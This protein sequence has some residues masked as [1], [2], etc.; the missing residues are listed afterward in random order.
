MNKKEFITK[1]EMC[2]TVFYCG[3]LVMFNIHVYQINYTVELGKLEV[4]RT[5]VKVRDIKKKNFK[6]ST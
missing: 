5:R 4:E 6:K 2:A 1:G 3:S